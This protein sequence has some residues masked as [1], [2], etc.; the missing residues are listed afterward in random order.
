MYPRYAVLLMVAL[1]CCTP[2]HARRQSQIPVSVQ[3]LETYTG[4]YQVAPNL[5]VTIVVAGD[6][7]VLRYG[8][9]DDIP[10]DALSDKIFRI[11]GIGAEMEF[12]KDD[13]GAVTHVLLT[14]NGQQQ[15]AGRVKDRKVVA[16]PAEILKRYPGSYV[17]PSGLDLRINLEGDSLIGEASGQFKGTLFAESETQFFFEDVDAQIEFGKDANGAVDRLVLHRGPVNEIARR[18]PEGLPTQLTDKEF[19]KIVTDFSEPGGRYKFENFVSNEDDYQAVLPELKQTFDPNSIFIGVG[20]EQNLTYISAL[21]PRMAFVVDI[22]RQNMLEQL[23]YKVLFEMSAN[24]V[25]FV[26]R[27]FSRKTPDGLTT[28]SSA[29]AIFETFDKVQPDQQF[30]DS[31]LAAAWEL[32]T[33]KHGFELSEADKQ[34]IT[35]VYT[36]F[37]RGGPAMD[38]QTMDIMFGPRVGKA[39]ATWSYKA[40]MSTT[41]DR[42][43]H[44]WSYLATEENFRILQDYEKKNLIVPLVGDFAGPKT[45]RAVGQYARDHNATIGLFYTS[46]V[47][48]YL[49]VNE[50]Q[51]KF[52]ANVATF[53]L[54]PSSTII[55]V[56]GGPSGDGDGTFQVADGKK[57]AALVC[58]F[59]DVVK[60]FKAGEIQTRTDLNWLS[61]RSI[62]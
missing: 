37:F 5:K 20:P 56:N 30:F 35:K 53:P 28:A 38:Y 34:G 3:V 16:V 40:L 58:S 31:N 6:R 50:V 29:G 44:N 26:S 62:D 24:R 51:D 1:L 2:S 7:L 49:F 27:L 18:R 42:R 15:R 8:N 11:R 39:P 13:H 52:L 61:R 48:E 43:G 12:V 14:Q 23:I 45:L 46:N 32:L 59:A 17:R 36:A 57:W 21:R 47:D 33:V 4:T 22:R 54:N 19:W 10:L 41:T 60:G 25:E 55:R 9:S